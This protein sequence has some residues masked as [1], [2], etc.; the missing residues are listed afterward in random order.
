MAYVDV[1]RASR[2]YLL[3]AMGE[4]PSTNF[5]DSSGNGRNATSPGS[6]VHRQGASFPGGAGSRFVNTTHVD[7]N[8][9]VLIG[10][11][12]AFDIWVTKLSHLGGQLADLNSICG[13]SNLSNNGMVLRWEGPST[14]KLVYATTASGYQELSVTGVKHPALGRA[15][16]LAAS[17]GAAGRAQIFVNGT[18]AADAATVGTPAGRNG[19]WRL[20]RSLEGRY[21]DSI[22]GW[23]GLYDHTLDLSRVRAHYNAGRARLSRRGMRR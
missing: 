8:A 7:S 1:V 10:S 21:S 16:H 17:V 3:W 12:F 22:M 13:E 4:S 18:L 23:H 5:W 15:S 20:G 2:P 11:S 6:N 14:L 9:G 19:G